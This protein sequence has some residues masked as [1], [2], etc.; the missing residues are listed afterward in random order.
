MRSLRKLVTLELKFFYRDP[1]ALFFTL[2]F[3][4]MLLL[5]FGGMDGNAA[6]ERFGG[7]GGVDIRVPAYIGWIL[8][9]TGLLSLT[10]ALAMNR[11]N[12]ILRLLG[13]TPLRPPVL[14]AAYVLAQFIVTTV[15]VVLLMASAKT[16]FGLR[17]LGNPLNLA[18]AYVLSA[19]SF[20]TV[21]FVLASVLPT[22]Q[23]TQRVA[24]ML[25]F[26]MIFLTGAAIPIEA[27]PPTI[28]QYAVVLPITHVVSLLRGVW[29]G[30]GL[31]AHATELAILVGILIVGVLITTRKFRWE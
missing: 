2:G 7:L 24:M 19:F 3:P 1:T 28:Q 9:T 14:L 11:E 25:F 26:P 15:G 10:S 4:L 22:A 16:A 12:G 29:A 8:A 13:A 23:A 6:R 20:Y 17:F 18:V 31:G 21:S 27:L 5:L 30:Q